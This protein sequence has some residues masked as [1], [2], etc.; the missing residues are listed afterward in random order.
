MASMDHRAEIERMRA[1]VAALLNEKPPR[2]KRAR[3]IGQKLNRLIQLQLKREG[4]I[5]KKLAERRV[6]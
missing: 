3:E 6:A 2:R 4:R 1:Q 5:I